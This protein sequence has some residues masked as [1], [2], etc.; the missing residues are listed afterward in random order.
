MD[1]KPTEGARL[2]D[3]FDVRVSALKDM[4]GDDFAWPAK[5]GSRPPSKYAGVSQFRD[6]FREYLADCQG[7]VCPVCATSLDTPETDPEYRGATEFNHLVA[8][9]EDK[10]GYYAGNV[11]AGHSSCNA[12]TKPQFSKGRLIAGK[13]ILWASD[14]KCP[15]LVP[16]SWLSWTVIARNASK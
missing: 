5:G 8:A 4:A 1:P 9:G 7:R 6:V 15:T 11:F 14:L 3:D 12:R 10:R 16:T 2:M 13:A